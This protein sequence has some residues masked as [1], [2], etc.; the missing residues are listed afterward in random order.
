MWVEVLEAGGPTEPAV[1]TQWVPFPEAGGS[2]LQALITG[3]RTG[4]LVGLDLQPP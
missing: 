2:P 4:A 3:H 1:C